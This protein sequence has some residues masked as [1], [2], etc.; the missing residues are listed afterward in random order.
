MNMT[1]TTTTISVKPET[2]DKLRK[3]KVHPNQSDDECINL[4]LDNVKMTR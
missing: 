4:I 2:K 1:T 3:F